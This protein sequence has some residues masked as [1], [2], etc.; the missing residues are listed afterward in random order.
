[1]QRCFH[2]VKSDFGVATPDGVTNPDAS[3]VEFPYDFRQTMATSGQRLKD[4]IDTVRGNRRVIVCLGPVQLG[5]I[6]LGSLP[7]WAAIGQQRWAAAGIFVLIW[8]A[9]LA[10]A[11]API[12]GRSTLGWVGAAT[13][14]SIAAITGW[15]EFRSRAESGTL[16]DLAEP[17]LPGVLRPLEIMESPPTGFAGDNAAMESFFSLLQKN[18][19]NRRVWATREEL[20]IAIVVWIER[21]YHRQRRQDRLGRLT[22]I[23]FETIMTTP[24]DQAA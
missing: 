14:F 10:F 8:L 20:R 18:V 5:V 19:L 15:G 7:V 4:V 9:V 12:G 6:C 11:V 24:A 1:M 22:P 23:E 3:V 17:D 16:G 2:L 13:G 21:T